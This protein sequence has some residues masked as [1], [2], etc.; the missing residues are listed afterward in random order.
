MRA[1]ARGPVVG[2]SRKS[3]TRLS[4]PNRTALLASYADGEPVRALAERFGVHPSTVIALARR[5]DLPHH[6]RGLPE[7]IRREAVRLYEEGLPLVQVAERL[8]ISKA[9]ARSGIVACG[10][11]LRRPGRQPRRA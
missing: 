7:S 9:G 1:D 10:G 2:D 5:A 11:T 8:G 6:V 4:I 3:L